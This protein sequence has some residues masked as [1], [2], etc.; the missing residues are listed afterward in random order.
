VCHYIAIKSW[1][2]PRPFMHRHEGLC[3]VSKPRQLFLTVTRANRTAQFADRGVEHS[4]WQVE[5]R[6]GLLWKY[7][8]GLSCSLRHKTTVFCQQ[9]HQCI[10]RKYC[11]PGLYPG[12][13]WTLTGWRKN[14]PSAFVVGLINSMNRNQTIRG[15]R[16]YVLSHAAKGVFCSEISAVKYLDQTSK[17]WLHKL[18][19]GD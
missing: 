15:N 4:C 10:D 19:A 11:M 13:T 1:R 2:V 5:W 18:G 12:I 14:H 7:G 3:W 6:G 8:V 16:W 9:W 17:P